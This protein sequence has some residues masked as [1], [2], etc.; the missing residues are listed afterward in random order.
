MSTKPFDYAT[1][2]ISSLARRDLK[3]KMMVS[4]HAEAAARLD[5]AAVPERHEIGSAIRK[6]GLE[7]ASELYFRQSNVPTVS[8]GKGIILAADALDC[9][10]LI[11]LAG[12]QEFRSLVQWN[13]YPRPFSTGHTAVY[14]FGPLDKP[15]LH[16]DR[17][18]KRKGAG[19]RYQQKVRVNQHM[20]GGDV[21]FYWCAISETRGVP[22]GMALVVAV[23]RLPDD[24]S[25]CLKIGWTG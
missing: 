15:E 5:Q 12:P 22:I 8:A 10:G 18:G 6:L 3:T 20:C 9:V 11:E 24:N 25:T 4:S 16:E 13:G 14:G 7:R 17:E 21:L 23:D 2:V 1:I 19:R